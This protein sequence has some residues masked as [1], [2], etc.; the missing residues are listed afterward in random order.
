MKKRKL[1]NQLVGKGGRGF[2]MNIKMAE[3]LEQNE[4]L[5]GS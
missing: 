4:S 5:I 2:K 1:K 3:K